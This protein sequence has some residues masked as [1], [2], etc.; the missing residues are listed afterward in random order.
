MSYP[1]VTICGSM[2]FYQEMLITAEEW[3]R[4]GYIVLMPF[5]VKAAG[6]LGP[7]GA[8]LDDM[9]RRKI[10]MCGRV[11]VVMRG[12]YM[13]DSTHGEV[14]YADSLNIP[15][16]FVNYSTEKMEHKRGE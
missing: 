4:N 5:S 9:H 1:V 16:Q 15:V 11:V 2:K 3:T 14:A 12:W 8:M 6:Q 10:D 13:G 7:D